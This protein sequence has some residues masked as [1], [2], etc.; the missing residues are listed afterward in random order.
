MSRT[1]AASLCCCLLLGCHT[2]PPPP[3]PYAPRPVVELARWQALSGGRHVATVRQMEIRDPAG[4][5]PFYQILDP[6]GRLLGTSDAQGR[7][8]RRVPFRDDEEPLGVWSMAQGVAKL[9]EATAPVELVPVALDADAR[10]H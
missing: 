7:F 5:V 3:A 4:A 6:Q 9:A 10:K 8:S 2:E 1:T